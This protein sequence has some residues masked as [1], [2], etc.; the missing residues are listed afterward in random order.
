MNKEIKIID[1]LN[2]I[3]EGKKVP[4]TI[5]YRG[6][7][8]TLSNE[9]EDYFC[10]YKTIGLLDE[11][12]LFSDLNET[13]EIIEEDNNKIEKLERLYIL[14]ANESAMPDTLQDINNKDIMN[15]INE[16]I[17]KINNME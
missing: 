1:L 11:I 8:Y 2:M 10:S 13:V 16:I 14:Q 9:Q 7:I 12:V 5:I 3:V 4:K 17:D 15:K 6:S